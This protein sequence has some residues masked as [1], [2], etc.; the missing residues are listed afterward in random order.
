[1]WQMWRGDPAFDEQTHTEAASLTDEQAREAFAGELTFGTGGLRGV[2][3]VGPRRVNLY[4]GGETTR[5][6]CD[7]LL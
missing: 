4:T 5:G 6:L 1:M 7:V 3:G 2:I